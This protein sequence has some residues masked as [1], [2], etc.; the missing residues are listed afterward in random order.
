[1]EKRGREIGGRGGGP[2]G[3]Q[4][5]PPSHGLDGVATVCILIPV[6][7][8]RYRVGE[9]VE[10]V[11]QAPLPEGLRRH[12]VLVD[13]GSTDGTAEVLREVAD[14]YPGVVTLLRH[15][16]NQGKGAAVRT[17]I[18][19]A[20]GEFAIIQ[21]ADLE[22]DPQDYPTLLAPLLNNKADAVFGSRFTPKA[23]RRVLYFWHGVVNGL[24]TTLSNMATNLNLTDME[25]GYKAFRLEILKSIPLRCNRFGMEPEITAKVAKRGLK[26]YE[27]PI[28]YHG[29][30]YQEGKKITWRDGLKALAAIVYYW[31]IDDIYDEQYGQAILHR[32]SGARRFNN[33]MAD[34]IKPFVGQRV[35]E[36]GSG[37]GNLTREL[38]PREHYTAS[39]IDALHLRFLHNRYARSQRVG[40]RRMDLTEP[41][42]FEGVV[43]CFDTVIC[44]NVLEH[45]EDD[46]L[47]LRNMFEV[48]EP[49]GHAVLLVPQGRWLFGSLDEVLGHHRRYTRVELTEKAREAGFEVVLV[50]DFNRTTVPGWFVNAV[51]LRRKHFSRLQLKALESLMWLVRRMD[52]FLPW[53][54]VSLI[55]QLRRPVASVPAQYAP[56]GPVWEPPRARRPE[57]LGTT[58]IGRVVR[59]GI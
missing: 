50:R 6:Y 12:L 22:Y 5:G 37:L 15:E 43:G 33:W 58:A 8:E 48:L 56:A 32:L 57:V 23:C 44:L 27:V 9:A 19:A 17:A 52:H 16:R 14:R 49:G 7:N 13:D 24:L 36:I 20:K 26:V 30:T 39:D 10:Q 41:S 47:A 55:A 4:H 34:T 45:V 54:G 35:L 53:P 51:L 25:T 42:H 40:I 11:L 59:R 29:R 3:G 31:L 18:Q 46:R 2:D 38:L 28:S 21:D 1:M